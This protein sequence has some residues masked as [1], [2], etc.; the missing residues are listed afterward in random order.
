MSGKSRKE[1][2]TGPPEAGDVS[3]EMSTRVC[4]HMN[5][6]HAVSVYAMARRIAPLDPGF[7]VSEARMKKLTLEGCHI[8]VVACRQDL[9][10]VHAVVF[11]F[12]APLKSGAELRPR[13]VAIHHRV[14]AP[15]LAWLVRK[16]VSVVILV[17]M[18]FLT[19]CTMGLGTS[20]LRSLIEADQG[21]VRIVTVLF[22]SPKIFGLLVRAAFCFGHTAH[23][24]EAVY[25][26]Y[27]CRQTL[28]LKWLATLQW[29]LL[30]TL[31]GFPVLGELQSLVAV[32]RRKKR[33]R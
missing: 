3:E 16:P 26:L 1:A 30:I 6:D 22:G 31:T 23:A 15:E 14:C 11:P 24:A 25:G 8:Q 2:S 17:M 33:T 4:T 28:K 10:Q 7:K 32:A 20:Q 29:A 18:A 13:L 19:Y 5:E 21:L 12:D 9:C 27:L